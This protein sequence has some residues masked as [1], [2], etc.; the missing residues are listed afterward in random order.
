MTKLCWGRGQPQHNLTVTW[1]LEHKVF[2]EFWKV[3]EEMFGPF[4]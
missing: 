1:S 4:S 3:P 2:P